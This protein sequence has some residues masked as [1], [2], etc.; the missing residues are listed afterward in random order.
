MNKGLCV[1]NFTLSRKTNAEKYVYTYINNRELF[2]KGGL[3]TTQ[4]SISREMWKDVRLNYFEYQKLAQKYGHEKLAEMF[5]TYS[6]WKKEKGNR[7]VDDYY[8]LERGWV[9]DL[10]KRNDLKIRMKRLGLDPPTFQGALLKKLGDSLV[11]HTRAQQQFNNFFKEETKSWRDQLAS[12]R[13]QK[14]LRA[15][16][17]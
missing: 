6:N 14:K 8:E 4:A 15:A 17:S 5:V 2:K 7:Q 10:L 3:S 9:L 16:L 11:K 12:W 1:N 13:E